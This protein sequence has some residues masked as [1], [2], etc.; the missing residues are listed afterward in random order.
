MNVTFLESPSTTASAIQI[1]A[2]ALQQ[3]A[4]MLNAGV[5]LEQVLQ[6]LLEQLARVVVY[7]SASVMLVVGERL[8]IVAHRGFQA[9]EHQAPVAGAELA[10]IQHVLAQLMHDELALFS[11]GAKQGS[12]CTLRLPPAI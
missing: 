3:V 12:V 2:D 4:Q 11:A 5:A 7:D 1:Q 9:A 6:G 10:H 8:R